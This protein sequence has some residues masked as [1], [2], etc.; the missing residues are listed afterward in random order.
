M[1]RVTTPGKCGPIGIPEK[2]PGFETMLV[3][4]IASDDNQRNLILDFE[5]LLHAS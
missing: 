4:G 3:K 5:R 2:T 1:A